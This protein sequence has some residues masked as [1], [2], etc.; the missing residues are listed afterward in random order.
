MIKKII[1]SFFLFSLPIF[2][3]AQYSTEID[4]LIKV[5]SKSPDDTN[6]VINL[7]TICWKLKTKDFNVA[8]EYGMQ[9]IDLAHKINFINGKAIANKNLGG[10]Y[11]LHSDYTISYDYYSQGLILFNE[12]NDT[13]NAAKVV[14]NLGSIFHQ[15]GNYEKAIEYYF[16]SLEMRKKLHDEKGTA[17]LYRAIGVVYLEQGEDMF[18]KALEYFNN[19]L[20]LYNKIDNKKG[21]A[22]SYT[23]IGTVYLRYFEPKY[24][25]ALEYYFKVLEIGKEQND[26][27]LIAQASDAIG[28][29]YLKT[30][31]DAAFDYLKQSA[32]LWL[33]MEN[34]FGVG[35]SYQ[36]F[37]SYYSQKG[38]FY[39]SEK[40]F[41]DAIDIAQQINAPMIEKTAAEGLFILYQEMRNYKK[42]LKYS[43]RFHLL[44]DSLQSEEVAKQ[45]T[46]FEMQL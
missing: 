14:R 46:Q 11:Y 17:S 16:E 12:I 25:E 34:Y 15:Q 45:M 28:V 32:D 24:E 41:I 3:F 42:S 19:A 31:F 6:K 13:I 8:I 20:E 35:T 33:E 7:N 21:I 29:I 9:A 43:K 39:I 1:F 27:R 37:G 18:E 38:E 36:N 44:K 2:L 23:G 5:V 30:K 26:I 40:Y 10:V 4:S 22:Q